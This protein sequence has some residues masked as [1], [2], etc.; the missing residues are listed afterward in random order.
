[1][2]RF[3]ISV[4]RT[5]I[6]HSAPAPPDCPIGVLVD[7]EGLGDVLLKLPLLR[8]IARGFL[9]LSAGLR[10]KRSATCRPP[11]AAPAYREARLEPRSGSARR[12]SGRQWRADSYAGSGGL[13]RCAVAGGAELCGVWRREPGGAQEL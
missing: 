5:R 6:V 7:R 1:M 4:S 8:A 10:P 3:L 13:C 9:L 12:E 11:D 2:S